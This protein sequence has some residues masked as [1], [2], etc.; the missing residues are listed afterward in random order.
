MNQTEEPLHSSYIVNCVFNALSSHTA[1]ML[2]II[3]IV[4]V[5]R[6]SSLPKSLKTL[7]LSLAVSDLGVGLVV[8]PFYIAL[9]V[10]LLQQNDIPDS[11]FKA[12]DF[13]QCLFFYASF[14]GVVAIITDRFLSIQLH[15]RYHELVTYKRVVAVVTSIW[16]FSALLSISQLWL[17]VDQRMH[18]SVVLA[19]IFGICFICTTIF[20]CRIYFI[21]R[22]HRNQ[23]QVLQAQQVAQNNQL[24]NVARLRKSAVSTFYIYLVF[25]GCCLPEYGRLVVSLIRGPNIPFMLVYY[26]F[27]WTLVFL[28]SSL[29]PVIYC[30]K[31]A[32]IRKTITDMLRKTIVSRQN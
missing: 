22:R 24:A 30:W 15:L 18:I 10:R 17:S 7:L 12:F 27:T 32:H 14:F 13:F 25:I 9:M 26:L 23:M 29:N 1:I 4:A 2:N 21:M 5:K 11:A 31:M 28:N 3:T 20:N 19:V 8:Q 6:T 16:F